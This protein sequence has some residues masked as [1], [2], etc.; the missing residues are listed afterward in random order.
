M[1]WEY[2]YVGFRIFDFGF[3][4]KID[5]NKLFIHLSHLLRLFYLNEH[6]RRE[7]LTLTA[8][9]VFLLYCFIAGIVSHITTLN[10]NFSGKIEKVEYPDSLKHIPTIMVRGKQYN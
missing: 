8:M 10:Y 1:I 2:G 5:L 6:K 3:V 7:F 4:I 9:G